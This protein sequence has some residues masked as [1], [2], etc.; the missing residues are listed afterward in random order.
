MG[1]TSCNAVSK[2]SDKNQ[3]KQY[4][5][6]TNF[7]LRFVLADVPEQVKVVEQRLKEAKKDKVRIKF[8][9]EVILEMEFVLRSFYKVER[10]KLA[11]I[12][13]ELC[14]T[15]YLEVENRGLWMEALKMYSGR[16][17]D[18]MDVFLFV[19]AREMGGEVLSFDQ[20]LEKLKK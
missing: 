11:E 6:D 5:A 16:S 12:L 2:N 20:D 3:M 7:Y 4:L 13:L 1:K 10:K 18:L 17:I 15:G 19:K 8:V 9:D 14:K